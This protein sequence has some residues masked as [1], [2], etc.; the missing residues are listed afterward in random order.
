MR[1][2]VVI[3]ARFASERFP[4]KVIADL[5]GKPVIQWVYEGASRCKNI[6]AVIVATDDERVK[7]VV[8]GF[9]GKAIMTSPYHRSGTERI[10]EVAERIDYEIFINVQ[11]DEPLIEPQ[12][13]DQVINPFKYSA[14]FSITTLKTGLSDYSELIDPNTVKVVTD[15]HGYALYF[16]RSPIP[17]LRNGLSSLSDQFNSY[18][19]VW[20]K[21]IGIYGYRRDFLLK[22]KDLMESP[23]ERIEKLEQLRAL[24]NGYRIKVMET[25]CET[26][27]IDTPEDLEKVRSIIRER[28]GGL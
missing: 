17:Y 16:S 27:G 12:M 14:D 9:G 25:E 23:L 18:R 7:K 19:R 11:G 3:P 15:C 1:A 2:I 10:A 5:E 6:E 21:H 20:F 4:G 26:S 22:W 8:E 28:M 24:E 13:V